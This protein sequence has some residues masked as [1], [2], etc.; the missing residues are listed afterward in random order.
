MADNEEVPTVPQSSDSPPETLEAPSL[1]RF[2]GWRI[3]I[4]AILAGA[5]TGPGQTIGV[6]VFVPH[7]GRELG[8]T[9][10]DVAGAYMAGTLLGATAMPRIGGW[11]DIAG[12]RRAMTAIGAAF[13]AALVAMSTVWALLPL[14]AGFALIRMFGQGAL[15]LVSSVAVSHWFER[16]RGMAI[17]IMTTSVA[18]L[19]SLV[20]VALTFT[21]D[22]FG[23]RW[24]WIV[25]G[26]VVWATVMPIGWFGMIDRP[27]DVGQAPDGRIAEPA[28][29]AAS[30]R[31]GTPRSVALRTRVM[32]VAM[33]AVATQSALVTALNFHQITLLGEAGL[34]PT[35]AALMFLPQVIGA[36]GASMALG[37]LTD[38]IRGGF[39][40]AIGMG[41]MAI[42]LVLV[43]G[44]SSPASVIV[45][46]VLLGAA[47]GGL[48]AAN[49]AL[50]PKWFGV[51]HLGAISGVMTFVMVAG[52]AVGPF[53]LS[54]VKGFTGA[55]GTAAT[56]FVVVPIVVAA[57]AI[58]SRD[59]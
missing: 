16:R 22:A 36:T 52:S 42:P 39:V 13:G 30:A 17:G 28:A 57:A 29:A 47:A 46:A 54:L 21:I 53:A 44:L 26:V 20:P 12:V 31:P 59:P 33:A 56:W 51:G 11:I 37:L 41:L 43:R 19:M 49:A 6:S 58:A 14:A 25:A 23:W 1:V 34:T 32:W 4:L 40:L 9:D 55:F 2:A 15:T 18:V 35:E 27:R 8:L 10:A 5:L 38:R 50:L 45:Y 7:L 3:L 24:A 48:F